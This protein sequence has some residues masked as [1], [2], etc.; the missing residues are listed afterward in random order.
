MF[1]AKEKLRALNIHI[2]SFPMLGNSDHYFFALKKT[3]SVFFFTGSNEHAHTPLDTVERIN[4][5]KMA[6][7]VKL[8]Y[9]LAFSTAD[10]PQRPLWNN[11]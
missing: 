8:A 7:V 11:R 1:S 9:T 6:D 5:E 3:L 10:E 4:A 2:L